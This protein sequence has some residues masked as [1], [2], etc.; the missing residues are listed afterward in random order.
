MEA[1]NARMIDLKIQLNNMIFGAN[2]IVLAQEVARITSIAPT[3][4]SLLTG[5]RNSRVPMMSEKKMI[6][7]KSD[8]IKFF[9]S[10]G[11]N[12]DVIQQFNQ[13]FNSLIVTVLAIRGKESTLGSLKIKEI[14]ADGK[15]VDTGNLKAQLRSALIIRENETTLT[16]LAEQT[17]LTQGILGMI[18]EDNKPLDSISER[19]AADYSN[20]IC[21][22]LRGM[23]QSDKVIGEF[24]DNFSQLI[25]E[26]RERAL[27]V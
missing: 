17:G 5:K 11:Q 26:S 20:K 6:G 8:F 2:S 10:L 24:A 21:R 13:T 16:E 12:N 3:E 18:F 7:I 25:S 22:A 19:F 23:G 4:I 9:E 14:E 15:L 1:A 27:A